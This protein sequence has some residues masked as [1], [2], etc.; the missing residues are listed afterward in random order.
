MNQLGIIVSLFLIL[1]T[2]GTTVGL[3][4]AQNM[5]ANLSANMN[6]ST[7]TPSGNLTNRSSTVISNTT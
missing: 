4:L 2:A 7:L 5:T 6:T 1:L 3:V